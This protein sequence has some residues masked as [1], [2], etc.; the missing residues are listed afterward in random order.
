MTNIMRQETPQPGGEFREE[1]DIN[2]VFLQ[3]VNMKNPRNFGAS[4]RDVDPVSRAR[5]H[6]RIKTTGVAVVC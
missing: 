1:E 6:I 4:T 2:L 3:R 5:S